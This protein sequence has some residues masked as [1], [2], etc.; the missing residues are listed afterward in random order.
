M[1]GPFSQFVLWEQAEPHRRSSA[2]GGGGGGGSGRSGCTAV[3]QS[4]SEG[5]S[6]LLLTAKP[7]E[8][9]RG[10]PPSDPHPGANWE[11]PPSY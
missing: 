6:S 8:K 9:A 7:A 4:F 2:G 3:E 1:I 10:A 5:V 11:F